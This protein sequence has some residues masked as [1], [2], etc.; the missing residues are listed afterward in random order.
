M[1]KLI[2]YVLPIYNEENNID[3]LYRTITDT[4]KPIK[5]KYD[6][7]YIFVNDGSKDGSLNKLIK[8]QQQDPSI[9]VIDFCEKLRTS[10]CRHCRNRLYR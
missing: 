5:Q 8:L 4:V 6:F 9:V 3:L 1:K 7:Q 2:S 10:N